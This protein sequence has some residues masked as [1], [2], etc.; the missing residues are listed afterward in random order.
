[1]F[2]NEYKSEVISQ[3]TKMREEFL[4]QN[5]DLT[6][7]VSFMRRTFDQTLMPQFELMK[8]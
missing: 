4:E 7:S 5:Q 8:E 3:I 2:V 6:Q 1:M